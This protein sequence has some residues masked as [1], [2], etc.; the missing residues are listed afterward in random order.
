MSLVHWWKNRFTN[1]GKLNSIYDKINKFESDYKSQFLELKKSECLYKKLYNVK[2]NHE[3]ILSVLIDVSAAISN[4]TI[5]ECHVEKT[6][7]IMQRA[8]N[9]TEVYYAQLDG[10][11]FHKIRSYVCEDLKDTYFPNI[12]GDISTLPEFIEYSRR[13]ECYQVNNNEFTTE[14][15]AYYKKIGIQSTY[16][17]P[18]KVDGVIIGV[19]GFNKTEPTTWLPEE[20]SLCKIF[21]S[22]ISM[23]LKR[24][25]LIE[26]IR[27][28]EEEKLRQCDLITSTMNMVQG[29][30]WNKDE[31][32][33]YRFCSPS[34]KSVF[35]GLSDDTDIT[36]KT[37]IELLNDFRSR[38]G[39]VH[40]YGD[41]C[42]GTDGHCKLQ[43][44]TCY[45][46]EFGY[47]GDS[48]F[49][50]DVVKTPQYDKFGE[51]KGIVGIARDRS[52]DAMLL[53]LM[54]TTLINEGKAEN[55]NADRM[56]TDRVAAYWIKN[57]DDHRKLLRESTIIPR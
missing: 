49:A 11:R 39:K 30:M 51:Y 22:L 41:I 27:N 15:L 34:F 16:S 36:G 55:L 13:G 10:T 19:V 50:L 48:L 8:F 33:R 25:N 31:N 26:G 6:A 44:T 5:E 21:S 28:A 53:D 46:L 23:Y 17:C 38:T 43:G 1:K 54:L 24:I 52:K 32:G 37:D 7:L 57:E 12:D 35:F 9:I 18:V 45:Y 2:L 3:K 4:G 42:F 56:F 47:I 29:F 20:I 14:E 40:T